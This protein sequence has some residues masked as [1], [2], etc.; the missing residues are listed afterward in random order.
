VWLARDT[1]GDELE[2]RLEPFSDELAAPYGVAA[3]GD[4]IDVINK[5]ALLRLFDEDRDGRAERVERLASGWGHTVDY[6]DWAVGLPR[7]AEGN[8]YVS[9]ACRKDERTPAAENLRGTVVR[10]VPRAPTADDPRKF[11]I[12]P[13]AVGLR[14]AQGIALSKDRELFVTDNQGHYT[15]FNELNHVVAGAHYG[16]LDRRAGAQNPNG[17][18]R[19]AAVEI[20]HPWTRSVNGICFLETP[21]ALREKSGGNRFGPFE[22][23]LVGCEYDT[24][25]LVRLSLE[26]VGENF[27]GAVYPFSIEPRA[28]Q[29]TFEGPLVCGVAPDGDLYIGNI[30]DSGWGAGTNTGSIVRMRCRGDLPPGIAEV[31]AARGGFTIH[32]TKPVDRRRAVDLANYSVSSFRRLATPAY[33][34]ED[35]DRRVE[36]IRRA[37]LSDDAQSVT[38]EL[39]ELRD[40]F[41][42]EF[43]L[44][45]LAGDGLFFPGEAY[46]TLRH[47][48]P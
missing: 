5:Y 25:R 34:G 6:H 45:S 38:L 41:V 17:P 42:Y 2:D 15:P 18:F 26:K 23:H 37:A 44:R 30:R 36:T 9:L 11:A 22:G 46:Y 32:F 14:F 21:A 29:E 43:H 13:I 10:L 24:R 27:Q 19:P 16:F 33:G 1:N 35:K 48:I 7:D 28:G 3:A 4:A 8:Y 31:R 12:E 20:P 39:G 47:R 40:G